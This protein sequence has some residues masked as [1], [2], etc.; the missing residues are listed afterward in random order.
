MDFFLLGNSNNCVIRKVRDE[1]GNLVSDGQFDL[2][3]QQYDSET[4]SYAQVSDP[5]IV[6]PL[7]FV[8]LGRGDYRV[9]LPASLPLQLGVEYR[10]VITGEAGGRT[11]KETRSL[12]AKRRL[13]R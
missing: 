3:I 7:A 6:W 8:P 11:F 9:H 1:D 4:D 12:F 2:T 10:A 5:S 13:T